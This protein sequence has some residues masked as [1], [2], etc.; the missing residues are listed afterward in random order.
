[1]SAFYDP[2][3]TGGPMEPIH[4]HL[5]EDPST[6]A[7]ELADEILDW[8]AVVNPTDFSQ[9]SQDHLNRMLARLEAVAPADEADT[10]D[11]LE[12]FH[13]RYA[14]LFAEMSAERPAEKSPE[15][16]VPRRSRFC[17]RKRFAVLTAA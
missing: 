3:G 1:M 13:L 11:A 17:L 15:F 5:E 4:R 12:A 2:L 6:V 8:L 10:R 16:D 9:E 7:G 14:P